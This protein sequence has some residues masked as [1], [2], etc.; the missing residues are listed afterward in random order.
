MVRHFRC[1]LKRE[2]CVDRDVKGRSLLLGTQR[3]NE[4]RGIPNIFNTVQ[5]AEEVVMVRLFVV[6]NSVLSSKREDSNPTH[7][8]SSRLYRQATSTLQATSK[9]K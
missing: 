9:K 2:P 7:H 6:D 5:Y 8:S 1:G 4:T 3:K